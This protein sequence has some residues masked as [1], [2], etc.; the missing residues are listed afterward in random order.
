MTRSRST[1]PQLRF[2]TNVASR[3]TAPCVV[4]RRRHRNVARYL[5]AAVKKMLHLAARRIVPYYSA[6][7]LRKSSVSLTT[8]NSF[9][10]S[11]SSLKISR[12]GLVSA[13]S[14]FSRSTVRLPSSSVS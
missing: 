2:C 9:D 6:S 3:S 12:S 11:Q 4:K 1:Q 8:S 10:A 7:N 14:K 5:S 13:V